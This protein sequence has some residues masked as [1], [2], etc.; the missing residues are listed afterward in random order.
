MSG[1]A[2]VSRGAD[3]QLPS[4]PHKPPKRDED[5]QSRPRRVGKALTTEAGAGEA[6]AHSLDVSA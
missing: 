5:E 4:K 1:I 6:E 2:P 3:G